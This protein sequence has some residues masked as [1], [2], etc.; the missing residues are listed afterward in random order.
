MA[1]LNFL[2]MLQDLNHIHVFSPLGERSL[3]LILAFY[4][5]CRF[6]QTKTKLFLLSDTA[7]NIHVGTKLSTGNNNT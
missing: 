7:A 6:S 4:L 5:Y 2:R 1:L 3:A